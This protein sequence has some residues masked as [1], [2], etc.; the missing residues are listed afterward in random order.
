MLKTK[1]AQMLTT[2]WSSFMSSLEQAASSYTP[3]EYRA[4]VGAVTV[5]ILEQN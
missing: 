4:K 1:T 3:E 5:A 2:A